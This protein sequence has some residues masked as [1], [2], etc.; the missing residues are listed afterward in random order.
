MKLSQSSAYAISAVTQ[1]AAVKNSGLI[2]CRAICE[3]TKMP[4]RYLLQLLRALVA[5]GVITSVRGVRGGYRLSKPAHKVT[6]LHI[7]EAIDGPIARRGDLSVVGLTLASRKILD[8][9]MAGVA[10]DAVKQLSLL[11]LADLKPT[12]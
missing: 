10:T 12:K 7:V 2:S 9:T 3:A 8:S 5:A 1:I 6:L 4:E 11:T